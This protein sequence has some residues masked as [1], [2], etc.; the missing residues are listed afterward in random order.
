MLVVNSSVFNNSSPTVY[1]N[2]KYLAIANRSVVLPPCGEVTLTANVSVEVNVVENAVYNGQIQ[3][4]DADPRP[5]C[6]VLTLLDLD[7]A[8]G[9]TWV[10]TNTKAYAWY[11]RFPTARTVNNVYA[12]FRF[13]FPIDI[14]AGS[15]H[16][17]QID[18]NSDEHS[19][20]WIMDGREVY[21]VYT[22]GSFQSAEYQLS[23]LGG[24]EEVFW[25][26]KIQAGFGTGSFMAGFPP[27]VITQETAD[28]GQACVFPVPKLG[29][30]N[31]NPEI[32]SYVPQTGILAD[33]VVPAP[34]APANLT[35]GQGA[36][37]TL[38]EFDMG[39]CRKPSCFNGTLPCVV[40]EPYANSTAPAERK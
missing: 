24:Q 29:L 18:L 33:Y 2:F 23:D 12:S 39:I 15:F 20:R 5:A 22:I 35:W 6:G 13:A 27:C 14:V 37:L 38:S 7:N 4:Y 21:K 25:P 26:K 17:Y 19:V 8:F 3:N 32:A 36:V 40:V 9:F 31:L 34:V 30:A 11:S 1:D 28:G 16:V 10:I